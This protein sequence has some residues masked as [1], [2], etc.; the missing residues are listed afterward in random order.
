MEKKAKFIFTLFLIVAFIISSCVPFKQGTQGNPSLPPDNSK[1]DK[2]TNNCPAGLLLDNSGKCII[3]PCPTSQAR[4]NSGNCIVVNPNANVGFNP[5]PIEVPCEPTGYFK[6]AY[7]F[8]KKR[9]SESSNINTGAPVS[10]QFIVT[11][12]CEANIYLEA[13]LLKSS[14]FTILVT[15]PSACD[16][17]PHFAGKFVK[18]SKNT[19]FTGTQAGIIDVAFFPQDYGTE[20]GLT[21]TGGVYSGCLRD[22]GK[23]VAE[24]PQQKLSIRNSYSDNEITSSVTKII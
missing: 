15:Q 12:E 10:Y 20:G 9:I 3:P 16:G 8:H 5:L 14:G 18:G 6:S 1:S 11:N 23:T 22:N 21:I 13:G 19:I 4:D 7:A 17:N 24:F 2:V